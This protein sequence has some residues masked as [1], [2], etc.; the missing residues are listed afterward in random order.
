MIKQKNKVWFILFLLTLFLAFSL[1]AS[2]AKEFGDWYLRNIIISSTPE[3]PCLKSLL[4]GQSVWV[5]IIITNE[6]GY[7]PQREG[8]VNLYINDEPY[9]NGIKIIY[10]E[11]NSSQ[12][13]ALFKL[14]ID[15]QFIKNNKFKIRARIDEDA[16]SK[17]NSAVIEMPVKTN[18]SDWQIN[19]VIVSMTPNG[20][21]LDILI[22]GQTI[23]ISANVTN[24]GNSPSK[25]GF[26]EVYINGK[27]YYSGTGQS[28]PAPGETTTITLLNIKLAPQYIIDN[29]F[30]VKVDLLDDE[31]KEN[32]IVETQIPVL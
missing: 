23:W 7:Q 27:L 25:Q 19:S 20:P 24:N 4:E 31:D 21:N 1:S 3:G 29:S 8:Y 11:L 16:D 22:P 2:K 18:I 14:K 5:S 15:P 9:G 6:S 10:P 13:T 12:K 28:Y 17:N 26:P 30:T 32:S